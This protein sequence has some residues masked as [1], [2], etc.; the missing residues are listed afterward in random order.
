M[1]APQ[2]LIDRYL[3]DEATADDLATLEAWLLADPANAQEL[4]RQ[5]AF[6]DQLLNWWRV[7]SSIE[8]V[9]GAA[10]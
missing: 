8:S 4:A 3:D 5:A 10:N 2:P 9:Q 1:T 7:R 6:H